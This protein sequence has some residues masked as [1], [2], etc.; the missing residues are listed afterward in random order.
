MQDEIIT[1]IA[2]IV[3]AG[4]SA[5]YIVGMVKWQGKIIG[6]AV[7]WLSPF[8]LVGDGGAAAGLRNWLLGCGL[9]RPSRTWVPRPHVSAS[10]VES[11]SR[12]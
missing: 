11:P 4:N 2:K 6:R 5:R 10:L 1:D 9:A 12:S 3:A 7:Y 8:E